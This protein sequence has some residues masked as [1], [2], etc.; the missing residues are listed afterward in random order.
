[1]S[2]GT[3]IYKDVAIQIGNNKGEDV[4]YFMAIYHQDLNWSRI[5]CKTLI[6]AKRIIT[7]A[8]A[9]PEWYNPVNVNW[10]AEND[11]Q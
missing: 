1:M 4:I 10:S 5:H 11:T 9:H 2:M 6:G 3:I 8:L 7:N